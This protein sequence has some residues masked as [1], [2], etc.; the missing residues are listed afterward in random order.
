MTFANQ[1]IS[2]FKNISILNLKSSLRLKI[3]SLTSAFFYIC[4]FSLLIHGISKSASAHSASNEHQQLPDQ[5]QTYKVVNLTDVYVPKGFDENTSVYVVVHGSFP[6][7]CYAWKSLLVE[8]KSEKL[9]E[10][11]PLATFQ[12]DG[13]CT[14]A[15]VPFTEQVELGFFE[16]GTH[17][18]VF[19]NGD[20]S[21]IEKELTIA[22]APQ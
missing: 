1:I 9:H 12:T 3:K 18:L 13:L 17:T 11:E 10:L 5:N 6:D 16:A 19:L 4:L 8:H 22:P 2:Q 7:G 20:G 14:M 15:L 21:L